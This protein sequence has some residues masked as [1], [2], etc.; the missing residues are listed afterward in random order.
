M[1]AKSRIGFGLLA[2]IVACLLAPSVAT[3]TDCG[4]PGSA[5]TGMNEVI[6]VQGDL[7]ADPHRRLP[8]DPVHRA[9]RDQGHPGPLLLRPARAA[10]AAASPNTLDMGVYQ[11]KANPSSPVCEQTDRRGWSGSAVKNLAIAENGFTDETTYNPDKKAFVDG[12]TTRAYKPGP[13]Q[14]GDWA[15]ELG[16]AYIDPADTD[17]IHF[18]VQV[19]TSNDPIWSRRAVRA[20]PARPPQTTASSAAGTWATSTSTASRNPATRR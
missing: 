9:G 11:P 6:N 15:V 5:G 3:A 13:I 14:A 17:G 12:F 18:H 7:A 10:A 4:L 1:R 16:I 19:L 2:G 20:R 8:A